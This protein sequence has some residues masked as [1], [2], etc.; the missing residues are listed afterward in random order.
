DLPFGTL[1]KVKNLRNGREVVV[2][3]N[4]RG[5]YIKSRIVDLSRAA[6]SMLGIVSR[7]TARV[8]IEVISFPDGTTPSSTL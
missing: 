6:A 3:V 5:P 4:D 7:G 1:I 8:S 2:R